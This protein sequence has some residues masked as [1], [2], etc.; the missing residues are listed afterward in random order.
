MATVDGWMFPMARPVGWPPS[1]LQGQGSF[2]ASSGQRNCVDA[3]WLLTFASCVAVCLSWCPQFFSRESHIFINIETSRQHL[4]WVRVRHFF[5]WVTL[6]S[7]LQR[8]SQSYK[9]MYKRPK[10][11]SESFESTRDRCTMQHRPGKMI[12][13]FSIEL[14]GCVEWVEWM[15]YLFYSMQ[16]PRV[17]SWLDSSQIF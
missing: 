8:K 10:A 14:C 17:S 3:A 13:D 5:P 11:H 15:S 4:Q 12:F 2:S 6:I 1:S 7:I 16:W 9:V